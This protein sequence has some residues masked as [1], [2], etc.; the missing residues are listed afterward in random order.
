VSR[1]ESFKIN[2]GV[3]YYGVDEAASEQRAMLAH[4]KIFFFFE[5]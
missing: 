4:M 1:R 2:T 5:K 3:D